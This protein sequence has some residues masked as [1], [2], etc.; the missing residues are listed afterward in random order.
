MSRTLRRHRTGRAVALG[1]I[2]VLTA[3]LLA[4]CGGG[5]ESGGKITLTWYIN[6]DPATSYLSGQ[7]LLAK[8]CS[9]SK[10]T[11]T[12]QEL[13][14]DATSQRQQLAYRL[15]ARDSSIDLMSM[16]PAF[17]AEFAAAEF[18]AP[19][20]PAYVK[21]F[22]K[23]KLAGILAT[24]TFGGKVIADPFWAN[25]QLLW[26]RKSFAKKAGLNMSKPVTWNQ[27][28][29]AA[30]DNGG[31]IGV[32][33]NLYEGYS[34]WI[35][36]LIMGAGGNILT[37]T[38]AGADANV[39]IDSPAGRKAAAVIEKLAHSKAAESDLTVSNEGTDLTP[40]ATPQGAF[41][42]NWTF[43]YSNYKTDP[44]VSKDLGWA[45]YPRT[46]ADK[47]SRAPVGGINLGISAFSQHIPQ[48][49][50]ASKCITSIK[51]QVQYAIQTGNMP[52]SAAAYTNKRLEKNYPASLLT[53][54]RDSS[55]TGG[56]RPNS[57]QWAAV[58]QALQNKWHP[59]TSVT[60]STPA[61]SAGYIKDVLEQKALL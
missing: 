51:S 36:A 45:P 41:Q 18:L 11:I 35:N 4:A 42:V 2:G 61:S 46:V 55:K 53:M 34:V 47:P 16:D 24:A 57:P 22:S 33:A 58:S 10:Y 21:A 27:I 28:I 31:T 13:P 26:Y 12:T 43:I 32:Q 60:Q 9:T 30:S 39:T 59:P 49:L 54:F 23:G 1:L 5:S 8:Q 7:E 3:S 25:T 15:A 44:T 40:F 29:D 52:A 56:P 50:Q 19:L 48:A 37:N 20:P 38:A 14:T 17:T 6:P